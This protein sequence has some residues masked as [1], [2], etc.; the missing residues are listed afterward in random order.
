MKIRIYEEPASIIQ[1]ADR[2]RH[3]GY[4]V[5]M[6]IEIVSRF[7]RSLSEFRKAQDVMLDAYNEAVLE[8]ED[9][10]GLCEAHGV[11]PVDEYDP[12]ADFTRQIAHAMMHK[13]DKEIE[14][15]R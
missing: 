9:E 3:W 1:E 6:P 8:E 15:M 12:I 10:K 4:E 7:R 13:I 14:S 5:D 2:I 11:L